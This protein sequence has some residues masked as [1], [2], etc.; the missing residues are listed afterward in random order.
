MVLVHLNHRLVQMS[1]RL[2]R[3]E[4]WSPDGSQEGLHRVDGPGGARHRP[5]TPRRGRPRPAGGH[6][7]RQ[8]AAPRGDHHGGRPDPGGAVLPVRI[9]EEMQDALAAATDEEPSEAVKRSCSTSGPRR[10]T[11]LHQALDARMKDRTDGPEEDARRAGRQ[12]GGGHRGDPDRVGAGD[13]GPTGRPGVPADFLPGFAPA[14]QEQFERN[15]DALRRR[16]GE[17][18]G[19]IERETE[20]IRARFADPQP[21]MFPV[22]VTFLVP[23]T[24]GKGRPLMAT[25]RERLAD[26]AVVVRCGRPPYDDPAPLR[27]KCVWYHGR[28]GFSVQ[29][30]EGI[31]LEA[32]AAWCPN[33]KIGIT[34]VGEIRA[35]GYDV[36]VT[37]GK[38]HHATVAVVRRIGPGRIR[39]AWYSCS[40]RKPIPR[41]GRHDEDHLRR[42][43]RDHRIGPTSP[44]FSRVPRGHARRRGPARRLGLAERRRS[45]RR[46]PAGC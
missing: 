26:E 17:I 37:P 18:P 21:R 9:A 33:R 22:A 4:V 34:T 15:D 42:L 1:L 40:A 43:Q 27:E 24:A 39:C 28:F 6:R 25:Q 35:L 14:E 46:R 13:P 32:L 20:A 31:P 29:S 10:P 23:G 3:A 5:A 7:R 41:R 12:G 2:L 8:P 45:R 36:V 30:A 38:G 19:E 11:P 44:G 16:V